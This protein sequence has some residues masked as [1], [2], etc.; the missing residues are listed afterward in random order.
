MAQLSPCKPGSAW[1]AWQLRGMEWRELNP[2]AS[3]EKAIKAAQ[4]SAMAFG[5][6]DAGTSA[7]C[8]AFMEA[9]SVDE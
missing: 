4:S 8:R 9:A 3:N 5:W 2:K 1:H 6:S 7:Y